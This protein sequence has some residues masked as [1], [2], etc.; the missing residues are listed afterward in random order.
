[1]ITI[2][3]IVYNDVNNIER[4]IKSVLHNKCEGVK[5]VIIDGQS[6]DGTLSVINKYKSDIDVIVSEKDNGIYDAM[7]KGWR[8][9]DEDDYVLFANSGDYLESSAVSTFMKSY[10]NSVDKADIYHG[11]LNFFDDISFRY[12]QGRSSTMLEDKMIE[13]PS[14]FVRKKVFH[15]IGGFN[16]NYRFSADYDFMLRAKQHKFC[17][18]FINSVISNFD[19][20]GVSSN[21]IAGALESLS[22]K[23]KLGLIMNADYYLR[24]GQIRLTNIIKVI[25][26]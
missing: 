19:L 17:F 23:K 1:M 24:V 20:S 4:T 5:Y 3:T 13:H 10:S 11:L 26:G 14:C 6:S 7:N 21:N 25:I 15:T 22:I 2:V 8:F 18:E 12:T 16:T 9:A